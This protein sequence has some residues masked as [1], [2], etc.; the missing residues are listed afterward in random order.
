ML[1]YSLRLASVKFFLTFANESH[2]VKIVCEIP[3][4]YLLLAYFVGKI[5]E[6]LHLIIGINLSTLCRAVIGCSAQVMSFLF[7]LL[8]DIDN[9]AR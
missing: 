8:V 2:L 7:L 5:I 9:W 1:F 4:D 3:K 6:N